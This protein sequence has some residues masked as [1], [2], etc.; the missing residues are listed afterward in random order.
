[1]E[2]CLKKAWCA[3]MFGVGCLSYTSASAFDTRTHA[4]MTTAAAAKSVLG[5]SPSAKSLISNL[6]LVD[7]DFALESRYIDIAPQLTTRFASRFEGGIMEELRDPRAGL[8]IPKAYTITETETIDAAAQ[9]TYSS[10]QQAAL[11]AAGGRS[12]RTPGGRIVAFTG[13]AP[14]RVAINEWDSLEQAQ[15]FFNSKAFKDLEPQRSKAVKTIR[16]YAVEAQP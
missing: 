14:K 15:A 12:F 8:S 2:H 6:G 9:A 11:K 1:M 10:L 7:F 4:V 13:D 5:I 16:R 3:L